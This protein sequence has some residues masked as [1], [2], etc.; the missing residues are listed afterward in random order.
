MQYPWTIGLTLGIASAV[1][2]TIVDISRKH[3]TSKM[4]VSY[5]LVGLMFAQIP[6]VLPFMSAAEL[7]AQAGPAHGLT[8]SLAQIAL[9][10]FPSLSAQY[11]AWAASSIVLNFLA[12][13]L[14]LR[15]VQISPLSLTTP[16]LSFTPVF[17]A[18]FAFVMLGE[19][20]TPLGIAGIA[21]VCLGA[22][23][24]N[25]GAREEGVLAPIKALWRER[26]SLY[27]VIV[28]ILWSI[29]PVF[30][31]NAADLTSP[32]W[33]TMFLALGVGVGFSLWHVARGKGGPLLADLKIMPLLLLMAGFFLVTAMVLQLASYSYIAIAYVE[34]LK[35]AV[36]V[37]GAMAAG[38]LVFGEEDIA[39]RF[40]GAAVMVAGVA[41]VMF[42]GH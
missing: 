26:G 7:G 12:N 24:L 4:R 40:L 28:A 36:G 29:T 2:W 16:Y 37:V 41:L 30:D 10:G 21:T 18:I 25:P 32:M 17:S 35:R 38:Y 33:H 34:T 13:Y 11:F 27:M 14:F 15:A 39:R 31:K 6:F 1:C 22:F 42:G 8:G 19:R 5:A 3:I 9:V 23:F 20:V